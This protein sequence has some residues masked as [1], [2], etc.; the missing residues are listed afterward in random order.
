MEP[1]VGDAPTAQV[2]YKRTRTAES[3]GKMEVYEILQSPARD[4]ET[5]PALSRGI[6]RKIVLPC[7][8]H[9]HEPHLGY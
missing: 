6:D 9:G 4:Y 7:A 8:A 1:I 2:L 5:R 3:I